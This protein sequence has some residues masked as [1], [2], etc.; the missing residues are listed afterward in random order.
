V[1]ITSFLDDSPPWSLESLFRDT[2]GL[3]HLWARLIVE[4]LVRRR[5]TTFVV[6][7]GSRSTP[8]VIALSERRDIDTTIHFDER[9]AAFYALGAAK[10]SGLATCLLCTSGSAAAHYLP[11]LIEASESHTSIVVIT[12]DRPSEQRECRQNQTILQTGIFS[13][14]VRHT[15]SLPP[16]SREYPLTRLL[17]QCDYAVTNALQEPKGPVHINIEFRTPLIEEHTCDLSHLTTSIPSRWLRHRDQPYTST[18]SLTESPLPKSLEDALCAASRGVIVVGDLHAESEHRLLSSFATRISWPVIAEFQSG[19]R[20]S[21]ADAFPSLISTGECI[22]A[23]RASPLWLPE[24]LP[25]LVIHFG[26]ALLGKNLQHYLVASDE[27]L[28]IGITCRNQR[29][30]PEGNRAYLLHYNPDKHYAPFPHLKFQP[31]SLT[32]LFQEKDSFIYT[33]RLSLLEDT[34]LINEIGAI[35]TIL[36]AAPSESTVFLGNSLPIRHA[37]SFGGIVQH[38]LYPVLQRGASGIDGAV[39]HALGVAASKQLP[40]TLILGDLTFL[41]DLTSLALTNRVATPFVIVVINNDGGGIFSSLPIVPRFEKFVP[42]FVSPHGMS[43]ADLAGQFSLPYF[44]PA[45]ND[46]LRKAL[47][48]SHAHKGASLIEIKVPTAEMNTVYE[49]LSKELWK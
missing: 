2:H 11:A 45:S 28:H 23:S 38:R 48:K 6:S 10:G 39:A 22:L 20:S 49:D 29:I 1:P 25:D 35:R 8:L 13:H 21:P 5:I 42:Y 12:A 18:L 4:S 41:H 19:L 30:D 34:H 16:P 33:S 3:A 46:E 15:L 43:F 7:P 32:R 26:D 31:S 40:M 14:F 24:N 17:S 47:H 27:T 36:H 44:K 9:G 37:N